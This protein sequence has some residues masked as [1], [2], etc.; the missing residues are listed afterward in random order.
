MAAGI[1]TTDKQR[2][3]IY[4]NHKE[5]TAQELSD[6]LKLSRETIWKYLRMKELKCKRKVIR[7]SI[8]TDKHLVAR[9]LESF[10][11]NGY[12]VKLASELCGMSYQKAS[13]YISAYLM[14]K[15]LTEST[16]MIIKQSAV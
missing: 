10:C 2:R 9:I 14:R 5:Y 11:N 6:L 8:S 13:Y 15:K 4:L 12:S 16:E 3:F 7:R 1:K